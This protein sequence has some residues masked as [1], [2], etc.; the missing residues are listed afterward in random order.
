MLKLNGSIK[1]TAAL[2]L[3]AL[4]GSVEIFAQRKRGRQAMARTR[5]VSMAATTPP[6]TFGGRLIGNRIELRRTDDKVKLDFFL[7][8]ARVAYGQLHLEGS[9]NNPGMAM[10]ASQGTN[11]ATTQ[12]AVVGT[13]ARARQYWNWERSDEPGRLK[14]RT[15]GGAATASPPQG[16]SQGTVPESGVRRNPEQTGNVGQLAQATQS[17]ARNTPT[18]TS[19]EGR[20]SVAN[21]ALSEQTQSL[22]TPADAGSG[23]DMIYLKMELANELNGSK[24]AAA[25]PVQVAVVLA[26]RDNVAGERIN[27]ALCR[28]VRA[29]KSGAPAETHITNLNTLLATK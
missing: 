17:T 12:A 26:P 25:T 13:M 7:T 27:Q 16:G 1:L 28:V 2:L 21:A 29:L 6:R 11:T 23:C 20:A 19:P 3:I 8:G 22:Y 4:C 10:A 9:L 15:M 5:P 18:P 24:G 14:K